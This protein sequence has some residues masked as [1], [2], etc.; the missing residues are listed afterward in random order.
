M[1]WRP[2]G[3]SSY[4]TQTADSQVLTAVAFIS[5]VGAVIV[6]VADVVTWDTPAVGTHCLVDVTW[7]RRRGT[8]RRTVC[9]VTTSTAL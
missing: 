5:A 2:R 1:V 6:A 7:A 9:T 4:A 8:Q 3:F